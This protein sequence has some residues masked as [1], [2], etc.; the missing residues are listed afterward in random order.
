MKGF[1]SGSLDSL[2]KSSD[3]PH[4]KGIFPH[5]FIN[6]DN[7]DYNGPKPDMS[8][9]KDIT[10]EEYDNIPAI[11]DIKKEGL[12]YL[13]LDLLTLL[14]VITKFNYSIYMSLGLNINKVKTIS[15]LAMNILFS[16]F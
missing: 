7:L 2:G 5:N 10:R 11:I 4:K 15:S 14:D 3:T 9:Y 12:K 8:Y 13:N 1:I 16:Y 6:K